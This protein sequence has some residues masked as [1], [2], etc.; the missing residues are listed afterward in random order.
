VVRL[1]AALTIVA[2][3]VGAQEPAKS[4]STA[5]FTADIR[6]LTKLVE[7]RWSYLKFRKEHSGLS[8]QDLEA[9][10]LAAVAPEKQ[11]TAKIFLGALQRYVA[12]L[13]D[14]HASVFIDGVPSVPGFQ[15]MPFTLADTTEGLMIDGL[16]P[17]LAEKGP[18]KRGDLLLAIDDVPVET[19]ISDTEQIIWASTEG[20]RRRR[21]IQR[22]CKWTDK[23][24][25]T[26]TIHRLQESKTGIPET[27]RVVVG[28]ILGNVDVRGP[29][30]LSRDRKWSVMQV[31]AGKANPDRSLV[32]A[33][34]RPG[35]FSQPKGPKWAGVSSEHRDEILAPLYDEY[36][37]AFTEF[38]EAGPVALVV[39]LR[40]NPGG[41]DQLGQR[42][43]CHLLEPG[44][45]YFWLQARNSVFGPLPNRPSAPANLPRFLG[46][47]VCLIDEGT[48]STADNFAACLRDVHP[49]CTFVGR[50]TSA[51]T[52]APRP[53]KLPRT[54]ARVTFCTM[55]VWSPKRKVI[56][57]IGVAPDIPV[58]WSRDDWLQKRDPDMDAALRLI[59]QGRKEGRRR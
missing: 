38:R 43:A 19:L 52:G 56:E 42:V 35:S 15:R 40:G 34:L 49:D 4:F 50:P 20:S 36:R 8:I 46:K 53:F 1:A 47:L 37:R 7:T 13:K 41:T 26:L 45:V 14:G 28:C 32:V 29:Y 16:T 24:K 59:R 39:D 9:A 30:A 18:V 27:S 58:R 21:A 55:R 22:L 48:F 33:Y 44:F 6:A 51:G 10:A 11:P 5:D 54:G 2:T 17:Q 57:G 3:L 31:P 25:V 12:G 23:K